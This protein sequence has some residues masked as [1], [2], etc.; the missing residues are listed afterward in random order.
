MDSIFQKVQ[1]LLCSKCREKLCSLC[2]MRKKKIVTVTKVDSLVS[3]LE[4]VNKVSEKI[5]TRSDDIIVY[6]GHRR[7]DKEAELLREIEATYPEEFSGMTTLD[8][9]VKLQHYGFPTRLLDVTLNPLVALYFA[10]KDDDTNNFDGAVVVCRVPDEVV[11]V[12]D[13]DVVAAM[14]NL[15]NLSANMKKTLSYCPPNYELGE[16]QQENEVINSED[17]KTEKLSAADSTR[18]DTSIK[19]K[20]INPIFHKILSTAKSKNNTHVAKPIGELN[21]DSE[22]YIYHEFESSPQK[23][24][25]KFVRFIKYDLPHYEESLT[26]GDIVNPVYVK[27]K[28]LNRRI[29][30]QN[31]AFLLFGTAND[32]SDF[33]TQEK[34]I[35]SGSA[36]EKILS[37]LHAIGITEPVLFPELDKFLAYL[38][39]DKC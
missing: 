22:Q 35:I 1:G 21:M 34:I 25:K 31:G 10:A 4:I 14:S 20:A 38:K 29:I 11:E 37:E 16:D 28:Q 15:A 8:K 33:F 32:N 7:E 26:L 17:K 23:V 27:P 13:S 2:S 5:R 19:P 3:F 12:F 36:K 30:A 9:L 39:K 6:R 24:V 18:V